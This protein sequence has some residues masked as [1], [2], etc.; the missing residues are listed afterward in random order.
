MDIKI[1]KKIIE[2]NKRYKDF[3][4]LE[5]PIRFKDLWA[6]RTIQIVQLHCIGLCEDANIPGFCGAFSWQNNILTPLDGDCYSDETLVHGYKWLQ[7]NRCLSIL[8]EEW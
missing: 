6:N 1:L 7:G 4:L 2:N 5:T 3:I 8:V